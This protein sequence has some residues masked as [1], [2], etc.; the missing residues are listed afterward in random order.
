MLQRAYH[1]ASALDRKVVSLPGGATLTHPL[2]AGTY[3]REGHI[4]AKVSGQVVGRHSRSWDAFTA[5]DGKSVEGGT[6][7]YVAVIE[8]GSGEVTLVKV[9]SATSPAVG[10]DI[11]VRVSSGG[12]V[13]I[14]YWVEA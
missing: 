4:M 11:D 10:D 7:Y 13:R 2:I 5:A 3:E 12:R 14:D 6:A 8:D 9:P 1:R